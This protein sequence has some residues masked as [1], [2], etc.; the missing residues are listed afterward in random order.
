ME[1][2]AQEHILNSTQ[3]QKLKFVPQLEKVYGKPLPRFQ[4]FG[5]SLALSG[6]QNKLGLSSGSPLTR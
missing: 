6:L 3:E 1:P 5:H 4:M 2:S